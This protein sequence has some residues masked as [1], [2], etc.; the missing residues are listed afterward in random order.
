MSTLIKKAARGNR[1]ALTALYESNVQKVFYIDKLFYGGSEEAEDAAVSVFQEVWNELRSGKVQSEEGFTSLCVATAL[2][3]CKTEMLQKDPSILSVPSDR[4]FEVKE[5]CSS[6][7]T[8][9]TLEN[10]IL[11][12]FD[13]LQRLV[14][15]MHIVC[16]YS[17]DQMAR[18]LG[19]EHSTLNAI[20]QAEENNVKRILR[21]SGSTKE[22]SYSKTLQQ[23]MHGE[24]DCVV[25]AAVRKAIE[26]QI[27]QLASPGEERMEKA[28]QILCRILLVLVILC[29][30]TACI[31]YIP[32]LTA[33]KTTAG[34]PPDTTDTSVPAETETL[35]ETTQTEDVSPEESKSYT[36]EINIQD[37]GT[38]RIA[39]DA[40][41]APATVE[42]FVSLAE[43][44]F[45]NGLT[46]HRI[47]EGF[48]M[49]GGDPNGDGTGG[50]EKTIVGE[51]SANGY[52]NP[53]SHTRGTI[54]MARSNDYNS[55]SSQFFIVHEDSIYLDGQYAAFG[56]VTDGMEIVDAICKA[57]EPTDSNGSIAKYKQPV[58]TS[59]TITSE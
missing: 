3:R 36:A 7:S 12:Q 15:L 9:E 18:L 40:E 56:Y 46:F 1:A 17:K 21:A 23:F 51:F 28:Y 33:T 19:V 20:L 43:S 42:N 14:F 47:I 59:I 2:C 38:I 55:G 24:E 54:S 35:L 53:L 31:V 37:Y 16:K 32:R 44:G 11:Q 25:P 58:I 5:F 22:Q 34:E 50:S 45:Y 4:K 27:D 29:I 48:M 41:A 49:Q 6:L 30:L 57:A 8:V 13:D 39:L 26:K 52:D 10:R